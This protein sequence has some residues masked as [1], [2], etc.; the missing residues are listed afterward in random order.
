M[1]GWKQRR[2]APLGV[3]ELDVT[4][5]LRDLSGVDDLDRYAFAAVGSG[6]Q[7]PGMRSPD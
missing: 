1:D 7:G 4:P 2:L 3:V 5:S 6:E